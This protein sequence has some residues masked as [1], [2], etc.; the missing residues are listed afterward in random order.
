[1]PRDAHGCQAADAVE[2]A[3][4]RER[5]AVNAVGVHIDRGGGVFPLQEVHAARQVSADMLQQ[6]HRVSRTKVHI[7][8]EHQPI[9]MPLR[10]LPLLPLQAIHKLNCKINRLC[11]RYSCGVQ[12]VSLCACTSIKHWCNQGRSPLPRILRLHIFK[13]RSCSQVKVLRRSCP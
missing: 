1:M 8:D 7:V 2:G 3:T 6:P 13:R 9:C 4:H 10:Q 12:A 11:K 5:G